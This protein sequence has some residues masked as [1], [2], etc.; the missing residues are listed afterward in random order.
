ME[1]IAK[2]S[3]DQIQSESDTLLVLDK[4]TQ[5]IEMVKGVD[6]DGNLKKIH[7]D[8]KKENELLIHVDKHGDLFSNFF[9]NFYRQ[10]KNPSRFNFFKVSEYEAINTAKD[11]QQ[12]VDQASP[13]EKEKLK[14]YEIQPKNIN[15]LKNQN[16]MENN[17]ENQEYRFQPEQIDWKTMEKFGLNQEK[18][19]K[20][21][22]MDSL[23]RG[24]KTNNLIP[25]TINLGTAVSK[26]DV[27]LSLQAGDTGQVAVHLHGIRR[28]PNLN[29]KFLGHEFT[30]EDKKNLMEN[31]NMGRVV[32]L[33]N[34]KT[35]EIIPSVISRDRL[36]NELVAYRAEYMKIPDEIKGVKLDDHQKQTLLEGK[37]L[38]LEG[39][40]SKKGEPFDAT[41]QF[42]ADKRY[43]EFIFNN[44]QSHQQTQKQN[45][46]DQPIQN[47]DSEAPK[48]FRDK[49][50]DD[51]QYEKFKAG[52][53]VY[54]DGLV[55]GKGKSYQGYITFNKETS[56]ID[57]SFTNPNKL[58]EKSQ[59][60]EDH[61]TQK[62]VNSDGKT[63]EATKKIKESL[64]SK[65]Q[66]PANKQQEDQQ[67]K[68]ARSKGRRM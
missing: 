65:Q 33:V 37:P 19:E 9:S 53:T 29:L 34:P 6:Q 68:Q 67:K 58:K 38:Y 8:Q 16:T 17:T 5:T 40:I 35:D 54:V 66:Q 63:N 56:K 48:V 36:T 25:I 51:K 15:P 64:Q 61:K 23:L 27:R 46:S 45:Q 50:L 42:N 57:F 41:V 62:A 4:K 22:A 10:L 43:V 26:M 30:D 49:E 32:E 13:E 12:Y 11:L 20:M 44:N 7:P 1:E 3:T 14:E 31:G 55:D 39:M 47:K 21:N 28:E 2:D 59:P 52:E 18:L 60:S 24:F